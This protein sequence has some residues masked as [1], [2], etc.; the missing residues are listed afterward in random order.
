[1]AESSFSG[2]LVIRLV[3]GP[4]P[5]IPW[6]E[7]QGAGAIVTFTGAVRPM[8]NGKPLLALYYTS[9]DP[10][11]ESEL[12]RISE[13]AANQHGLLYV[14]LIHSRGLV[15]AGKASLQLLIAAAHRKSAIQA[16]D[17]VID[18][19][20]RDVPIWKTPVYSNDEGVSE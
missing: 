10:M 9:Y 8:E 5:K 20:K 2:R 3:D 12:R 7:I 18:E 6:R 13:H 17:Q 14:E 4:A 1:M 11:A 16:M 19:L 15:D